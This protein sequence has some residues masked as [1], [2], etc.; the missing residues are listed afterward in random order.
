[1]F[2]RMRWFALGVVA[3]LGAVAYAANQLRRVRERLTP[4]N[5][6][7]QAGRGLADTLDAAAHLIAPQDPP[8]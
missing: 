8:S 6:V 4:E 5:L 3:S 1:M 7:R 2:V